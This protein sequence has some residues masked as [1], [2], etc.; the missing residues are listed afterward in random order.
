MG[1]VTSFF[2]SY[3]A[4]YKPLGL[5][6][7][8]LILGRISAD[9]FFLVDYWVFFGILRCCTSLSHTQV[10]SCKILYLANFVLLFTYK[11]LTTEMHDLNYVM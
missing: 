4:K 8:R 5:V 2:E 3:T 1:T 11:M 9:Y 7:G 10:W 6:W